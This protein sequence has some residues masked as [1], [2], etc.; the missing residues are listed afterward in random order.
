MEIRCV[1]GMFRLKLISS[2]KNSVF[3]G[4]SKIAVKFLMNILLGEPERAPH[5]RDCIAKTCVYM[6]VCLSVCLLV[7]LLEA[8]YRKF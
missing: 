1:K 6:S 3:K 4:L 8:I 2:E 5:Q 7:G